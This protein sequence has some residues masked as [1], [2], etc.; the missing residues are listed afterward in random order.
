MAL[1]TV[2]DVRNEGLSND[3][4]EA[5]RQLWR[6]AIDSN[7]D[8]W[9]RPK[10]MLPDESKEVGYKRASSYGSPLEDDTNLVKWKMR[11]VA[12]GVARRQAIGLAVTRAEVGLEEDDKAAVTAAR[13]ELNDLCEQAMEAV[14]SGEAAS[15]GTSLHA[16]FE[17]IDLKRD[18]G[19]VQEQW[20]PDVAA[21]R[22]LMAG[23]DV[24]DVERFVVQD[25]FRVAGTLDRA[26][27]TRY[28]MR[29]PDD[30]VIP[31]GS[32]LIGDVKTSQSM[33]FAGCK[34]AVQCWM[35][36]TGHPYDPVAKQRV[37]WGHEPPRTD[38]AVIFHVPSGKGTAAMFW[39]DLTT[40]GFAASDCRE[41][42]LWRN[43][44]GKALI[45]KGAPGE[46]FRVT[47]D[48]AE[49]VEEL[50][51][52]YRRAILVDAWD[53]EMRQHFSRRRTELVISSENAA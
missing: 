32:V 24:L 42:Y 48:E 29:A 50:T 31:A 15:I 6:E 18:A 27:R 5:R 3:P 30:T 13:R 21:Y 40:A 47:A 45:S 9:G 25:E 51:A 22:A 23:F 8:Q 33:D 43:K 17:L 12:R 41:V 52:A 49:T 44:N 46:D 53:E 34:F 11:Q 28:A 4:E 39:V 16:V 35:Y 7:R 2:T 38:W 36:A 20:R 19:H 37:A 26:V 1:K 10:I 14:G